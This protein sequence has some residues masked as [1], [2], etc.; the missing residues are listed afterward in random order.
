MQSVLSMVFS[1]PTERS[2]EQ[3]QAM[4]RRRTEFPMNDEGDERLLDI[5]REVNRLSANARHLDWMTEQV[6]R[7]HAL[8]H[9][10]ETATRDWASVC[11]ERVIDVLSTGRLHQLNEDDD[12]DERTTH[13][14]SA[15]VPTEVHD[16]W[17]QNPDPKDEERARELALAL[18]AVREDPRLDQRNSE[19]RDFRKSLLDA[20]THQAFDHYMWIVLPREPVD[21]ILAEGMDFA[22]LGREDQVA[23]GCTRLLSRHDAEYEET[24]RLATTGDDM[25]DLNAYV[26]GE[27]MSAR[28]AE[29]VFHMVRESMIAATATPT[30]HA[31]TLERELATWADKTT[32]VGE[33]LLLL[34]LHLIK[35]GHPQRPS[36]AA[37]CAMIKCSRQSLYSGTAKTVWDA[38][39][40]V[41]FDPGA[42][43]EAQ[44]GRKRRASGEKQADDIRRERD[45]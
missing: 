17:L 37:V 44:R 14:I 30:G 22:A 5:L 36:V 11:R 25:F 18:L 40:P 21:P 28:Y 19:G 45:D 33:R 31:E 35:E 38:W 43:L 7:T 41:G 16:H 15:M 10:F 6:H 26:C 34:A 39:K 1:L 20:G 2:L 32:P 24:P 12:H 3:E 4:P 23:V 29:S 42:M 9:R 13:P 27:S 8:W